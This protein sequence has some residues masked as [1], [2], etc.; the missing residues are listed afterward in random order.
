MKDAG[1]TQGPRPSSCNIGKRGPQIKVFRLGNE[2]SLELAHVRAMP[3]SRRVPRR[4]ACLGRVLD[5][6]EADSAQTHPVEA[7]RG[8]PAP[9]AAGAVRQGREGEL[10]PGYARRLV[11]MNDAAFR[12]LTHRDSEGE[13]AL[14]V[15]I[16][17]VY[18]V[19]PEVLRRFAAG[20]PRVKVQLLS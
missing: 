11:E 1:R 6:R 8:G 5:A 10:L 20:F 13:I 19:I 9:G 14:G 7:G 18:P 4:A 17:I 16:D 12:R 3:V 15:P 2:P